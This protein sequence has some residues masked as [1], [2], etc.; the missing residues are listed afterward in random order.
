MSRKELAKIVRQV[1]QT[2]TTQTR[3]IWIRPPRANQRCP[4]TNLAR[5]SI[6]DLIKER[7]DRP[8][9]PPVEARYLQ[10]DGAKR[11]IW[12]IKLDSL[13]AHIEGRKGLQKAA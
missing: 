1:Q 7:D 4:Y 8:G 9:K 11:G 3:P 6:L 12:L 13:L 5:S 2:Q 10:K